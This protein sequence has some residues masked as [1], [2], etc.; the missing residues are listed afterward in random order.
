MFNVTE[1]TCCVSATSITSL[2]SVISPD[3]LGDVKITNDQH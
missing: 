2:N 1:T 3:L